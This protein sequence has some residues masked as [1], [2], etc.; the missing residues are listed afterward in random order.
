MTKIK[1]KGRG[2]KA[3][4]ANTREKLNNSELVEEF[5][6]SGGRIYH[7]RPS[8]SGARGVTF[9]FVQRGSRMEVSS[10]VQHRNDTFTKKIGTRLAIEHFRAGKTILLPCRAGC[11]ALLILKLLYL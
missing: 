11:S 10:A 2:T 8:P 1:T 6:A 7:H 5:R 9:A 4:P 3:P